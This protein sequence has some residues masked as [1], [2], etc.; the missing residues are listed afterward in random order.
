MAKCG[1]LAATLVLL[2]GLHAGHAQ[3]AAPNTRPA[4]PRAP[5]KT[6]PPAVSK[7]EPPNWWANHSINPV[8][9]LVRGSNLQGARVST[10]APG[11]SLGLTRLNQGGTYLFVD[12]HIGPGAATGPAPITVATPAGA[13]TIPFES[14]NRW[15]GRAASRDST[16][17]T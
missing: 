5:S 4:Q 10:S 17:T 13:T 14:R 15:L 8:R 3:T 7:V 11:V 9:L 12:V 6:G 2:A 16:R 1:G